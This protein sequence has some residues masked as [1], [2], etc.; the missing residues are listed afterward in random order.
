MTLVATLRRSRGAGRGW[1]A[2]GVSPVLALTVLAVMVAAGARA[3]R[4][5][6]L[7]AV[8]ARVDSG[9]V[10]AGGV[11]LI[12][13]V[14]GT[15]PEPG[16]IFVSDA[17]RG[18]AVET[19]AGLEPGRQVVIDAKPHRV[20]G[21][22]R[23]AAVG[24]VDSRPAALPPALPI[25]GIEV[26]TGR[27]VGRRVQLTGWVQ[28]VFESGGLPAM[29]L[30]L[31]GLQ[32]EVLVRH[33][34]LEALR[35]HMG[36]MVRLQAVVCEPRG[37]GASDVM[38][39]VVVDGA[40]DIEPVGPQFPPPR[41]L[42]RLTTAAAVRN[43]R[44]SDAAAAHPVE[45]VGRVTFVHAP[46][47]SL[48]VQDE[49]GGVFVLAPEIGMTPKGIL[50]GDRL[51]ISGHTAPGDFAP[52]VAASS[53]RPLGPGELP[54][55]R[56][57]DMDAFVDGAL[58]SQY[59]ESSA[60][61]VRG[62]HAEDGVVYMDLVV[63][64]ERVDAFV[65]VPTG[66]TLPA[67][68]GVGATIR[69]D[70]VAGARYNTRR[71]ILGAHLAIPSLRQVIVERA[72]APDPFALPAA[73]ARE[74]LSFDAR[75][76][77]RQL[78]RIHG[79]VL[80]AQGRW[81][82]VSDDTGAVQ[83]YSNEARLARAGDIVDATGFPR[84]GG[85]T[86]ILEDARV[87]RTGS[88][89]LPP[90]VDVADPATVQG[91]R[92]GEL[93]RVRGRLTRVYTT[94]DETV[95]VVEAGHTA[96]SAYLDA[97]A[98]TRF[99]PPIGSL[100]DVTGVVTL[101]MQPGLGPRVE[102]DRYR[103]I[104]GGPGSVVV[105]ETP[106]IVTGERAL[107]IAGALAV[108]IVLSLLWTLTLRRRVR[109]QTAELVVAK[110]AA[111]AASRAKSEFVANMSHEIRTPMNGVLGVTELLL[112]LPQDDEQRHYLTMVKS[113]AD[114]LLHVI[115][116]IL[117]FSKIEAGR[118]DLQPRPFSV[119][120]FVADAARLFDLPARQKGL[121]LSATADGDPDVVV[122]D[123]ERLRQVLVNLVGNALKFTHAGFVTV[124]ARVSP[125]ADGGHIVRFVVA[126]TGI[127]V[128]AERQA[129]IFD[130]FTQ[131]DG[132][133]TRRYG[134]TGLGLSIA[135]KLVRMMGG[136]MTLTSEPG[137]GSTFGFTIRA[138]RAAVEIGTDPPADKASAAVA[139]AVAVAGAVEPAPTPA[140]E[141]IVRPSTAPSGVGATLSVLVAEDNPV[142]QRVAT[143]MLKRRG[144]QV[145]IAGNGA[146]AVRL[147]AT[148]NF[149][150]VFMDVQMPELDGLE[151]TLAIRRAEAGT[152][153]HLPIIAMTAHAMNGDRERCLAAG[154]DDYLTKPVSIA[155]ID[156]VLQSLVA[157]KAA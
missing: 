11:R 32:V 34:P 14:T 46:W 3:R 148:Q 82:Y 81:L 18:V 151:A 44:P 129:S 107:G 152:G 38:G 114:A 137:R 43:L 35:R 25:A 136:A 16:L 131:V 126:D 48:F 140:A 27:A 29:H 6:T 119:R 109:E 149:D 26:T 36:N 41:E 156:R 116:D 50:P 122:A 112:E 144:H 79:T 15:S 31:Q 103:L 113:S 105:V 69:L 125:A 132:S 121:T 5:D 108:A 83:V 64:R 66:G 90:P 157:S 106:P 42:R 123:Y 104:L 118:L 154:M 40:R 84:P 9:H 142:N 135:S 155:G 72:A 55:P 63:A 4:A 111:E 98:G 88:V 102:A 52:I 134:G 70:A 76:R 147:I 93:V 57:L 99:A 92:D 130:A 8:V 145:T 73:P 117:D 91:D 75:D 143:A 23:F 49:T 33:A 74:I 71:Q 124:S 77:A 115:D 20:D 78:T 128:P 68:L 89:T 138:T 87:R 60:V 37:M 120:D 153:H 2:A 94:P 12:G 141:A 65:P 133:I 54:S 100:V 59:V 24:L 95:L 86:P 85:F 101:A 62:L 7:D 96:L 80:V 139:V 21:R 58:D 39:R 61:V 45:I 19:A 150:A 10:E 13:V 97:S 1:R 53:I 56:P 127:G 30:S 22:L 67:G 17:T 28:S 47:N 51:A 110:D 146:E